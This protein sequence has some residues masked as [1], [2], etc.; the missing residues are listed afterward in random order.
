M[1][2]RENPNQFNPATQ[3]NRRVRRPYWGRRKEWM[4]GEHPGTWLK[5]DQPCPRCEEANVRPNFPMV[6]TGECYRGW[7]E[8]LDTK[9]IWIESKQHLYRECAKRGLSS[10]ALMSGGE[11]KRPRGA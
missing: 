2:E 7:Y 1:A 4:C 8:H 10:R 6:N 3:L 9:P 5:G 11:M